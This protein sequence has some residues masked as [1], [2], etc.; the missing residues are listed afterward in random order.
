MV[1][2]EMREW[3]VENRWKRVVEGKGKRKEGNVPE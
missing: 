2:R 1:G 3:E